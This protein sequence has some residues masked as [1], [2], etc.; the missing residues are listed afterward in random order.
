MLVRDVAVPM[1]DQLQQGVPLASWIGYCG[2][3]D[4]LEGVFLARRRIGTGCWTNWN[5]FRGSVDP[6]GRC[7]VG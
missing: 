3:L 4:Q 7:T 6:L 5:G 2:S 1:L